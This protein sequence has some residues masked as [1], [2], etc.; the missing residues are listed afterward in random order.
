LVLLDLGGVESLAEVVVNGQPLGTLWKPP[1][2]LD[3]TAWLKRG[4]NIL[5]VRVTNVWKNR[6]IGDKKYPEGFEAGKTLQFKPHIAVDIG[7]QADD[8]LASSGLLGPVR[9]VP[10]L[11]RKVQ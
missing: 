1:F 10:V 3:V 9:L 8:A 4:K 6:L 11:P 2:R 5:E 7:F